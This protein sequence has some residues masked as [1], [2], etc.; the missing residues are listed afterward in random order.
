[1]P[2][3]WKGDGIPSG[4]RTNRYFECG[5]CGSFHREDFTGDC[6]EDSERFPEVPEDGIDVTPECA[7]AMGCLC[8]FHARGGDYLLPCDATE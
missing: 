4:E 7:Q 6:R 2:G 3:F 5:C 8:A 1:M